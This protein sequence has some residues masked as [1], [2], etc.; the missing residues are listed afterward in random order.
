MY[1]HV[2]NT[3]FY[4]YINSLRIEEQS[5]TLMREH[6]DYT[7]ERIA[8]ESGFQSLSTFRR[9]FL[10]EKGVTPSEYRKKLL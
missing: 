8:T 1:Y 10:K 4:D 3:T 9:A 6:P 5:L 2:L 7:L